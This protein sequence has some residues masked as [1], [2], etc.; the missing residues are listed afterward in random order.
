MGSVL[1]WGQCLILVMLEW[2]QCLILVIFLTTASPTLAY[3]YD[4]IRLSQGYV[5]GVRCGD[6]I[7]RFF[8]VF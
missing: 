3:N 5:N 1:E 8:H 2:G 6:E 7:K 4:A